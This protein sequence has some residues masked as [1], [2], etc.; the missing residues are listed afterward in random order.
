[1]L[2]V[3]AGVPETKRNIF[4][5]TLLLLVLTCLFFVTQAVGWV[6]LV[7]AVVLG[8]GFVYFAVRLM[9]RPGIEGAVG[10]YLYSLAYLALLFAA[11]AVDGSVDWGVGIL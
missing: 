9:R 7:A 2:P 6:Y 11:I 10:T 4:L 5:Y 3:V 1:M 8:L